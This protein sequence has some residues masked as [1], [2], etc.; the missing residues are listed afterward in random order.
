MAELVSPGVSA[1]V[2]QEALY[3][4]AQDTCV[5]LIIL[6]TAAE[7]SHPFTDTAFTINSTVG[8]VACENCAVGTYEHGVVRTVTS[9]RQSLELYGIPRFLESADGAPFHG[10]ARNEY[11]LRALNRYLTQGRRAYV[12]RAN[13]NLNDDIEDVAAQWSRR[14]EDTADV[15]ESL[16]NEYLRNY[17]DSN[18]LV[19]LDAGYK[20]SINAAEFKTLVRQA[21]NARAFKDYSFSNPLFQEEFLRDHSDPLAGYVEVQLDDT[22]GYVVGSDLTGLDPDEL[23]Q[24]SIGVNGYAPNGQPYPDSSS[25]IVIDGADAQTYGA[26]IDALNTAL[27]AEP[28]TATTTPGP[29]P[30]QVVA[31]LVNGRIRFTSTLEGVSSS[32]ELS[33]VGLTSPLFVT[34]ALPLVVEI[35]PAVPGR[36]NV[37]LNVYTDFTYTTLNPIDSEFDGLDEAIDVAAALDPEFD[38]D[39]AIAVFTAAATE[40]MYTKEFRNFTSLGANDAARRETI[41]QALIREIR[42][43]EYIRN[44]LYEHNVVLCPGY[45]EVT[46]FLSEFVKSSAIKEEVFVLGS[47]PMNVPADGPGGLL[48]WNATAGVKDSNVAYYYP[49]AMSRNDDG[50][51]ILEDSAGIALQTFAYNDAVGEPWFAPAGVRRATLTGVIDVGYCSGDLG[52]PTDFVQVHLQE[53]QRDN[54]YV[55]NLNAITFFPTT[56]IVV[57][58]QKTTQAFA[59]PL[60][61]V[62]VS[63]LVKYIK[64]GLRKGSLPFVF[65]QNDQITREQFRAM[66]ENFLTT[67]ML[68][69]GLYDFAVIVD[70]TNNTPERIDRNEMWAD[71]AIKP[72][73]QAEFIYIP[74]R[75]VA[76]DADIGTNRTVD[77]SRR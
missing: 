3:V 35:L 39:G 18:Q 73:K 59:G 23:Y 41:V 68:R 36:G 37:A 24:V 6:A 40:Y 48:E 16:Y 22:R 56:G 55:S 4:Q 47:V 31:S 38:A 77:L 20:T 51:L 11:G 46:P 72:T 14:I 30:A 52:G 53:S 49:H 32:V 43:N 45:P 13:V 71:V 63:R 67:I 34:S 64:R 70:A 27:A 54:L 62:A 8:G 50:K 21:L 10:D 33:N 65:E 29:F 5:P 44:E 74:I 42:T 12:V 9:L 17:N 76:T 1:I 75:T 19:P 28:F 69:R 7:K 26:L 57:W 25:L 66:I 61:R 58:G 2:T 15:F 60:D